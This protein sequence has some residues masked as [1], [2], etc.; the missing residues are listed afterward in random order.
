MAT[1]D[2]APETPKHVGLIPISIT[3]EMKK[4]FIEYSMSV[5]TSRALPDVRDGLKPVHRRILFAMKGM[6]LNAGGRFRK[7]AAVVGEVLGKYH[8]H[9]DSS[10]YDAMVNLAQDFSTRYPLVIGQGNFGSIDGDN[11]AAQRYTEAKMSR[12]SEE[13]LRDIEKN[14]VRFAPNYDGTHDEPTVLPASV[15][16]LLL[17]GVLGIAVGM[18]TNIPPHNLGEVI[19]ATT[20]LIDHSDAT[21]DD[22][23]EH[24]QGPDFPLGG[25][26]FNRQDIARAYA[27]GR[28]GVVTR[29]EAEIIETKTGKQEIIISSIPYRV[30]RSNLIIKIADLVRDKKL[31]GIKD[32]RDESTGV[33][34]IVVELKPGT[35][36]QRIL[37]YI[38]KHTDLE[39]SFN[40]NMTALVDGVPETLSLKGIL[41]NFIS[42]REDVVRLR[43][44]Y[45]LDKAEARAH[46]L[47]GLKKALDNIDKVIQTIKKSPDTA[48][49]KL[50][51]IKAFK[52]TEI[53]AQAILDMR[54]Q[55]L[56]GLERKAI[57]DE[58][59]E[60]LA[61]IK[62]LKELLASPKK[63]LATI[64][65][66][67]V[68]IRDKY[69]DERRTRVVAGGVR[70]IS[71]ED[72]VPNKDATLVFT[73][74]GYIKRT[75]PEEYRAQKRGGKGVNEM[76]T[77]EE[78]VITHL[79]V[80]NTHSNLLFF[81]D[82]G[83]VYSLKLY[84]I[85]EGKRT[86]RGKSINNF[87]ALTD[88]ERVTSILAVPK[89]V[90]AKDASLALVTKLGVIKKVDLES[91]GAV[92]RS[93][94]IAINLREQD[95]LLS[96]HI[97]QEED[98]VMV[99]THEGQAIRFTAADVRQMGRTAAGVRAIKLKKNDQ[100]VGAGVVKFEQ[101]D[102]MLLVVTEN[103]Y[104]KQTPV[105]E[106][107]IQ[108]R[109]GGGV[110]TVNLTTKT[111]K[112]VGA[113]VVVQENSEIIAI[114]QKSVI[115][116]TGLDEISELGRA[117]QG[118]RIMKLA[119]GDNVASIAL[120]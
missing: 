115:I 82:Q 105:T 73:A 30:N 75:D 27:T 88:G 43:T 119:T 66:E 25:I 52:F 110:K 13:L 64:R 86:S 33:T 96:A 40:Y 34:R 16:N 23:L 55:K 37:N 20:H 29:G 103:G 76:N 80:A 99:A 60:K 26:V 51:L 69:S 112:L 4:S 15:P 49:A 101:P 39:T 120:L 116:R 6:G 11:A 24:I 65:E 104:G 48:T 89:G 17:N 90:E 72:L 8:P 78:D 70:N 42:H 12:I 117:T 36:P 57:E 50:N 18:A 10:V 118:V 38:Y 85:P 100:V 5:I 107:K 92:R 108:G 94:L 91:F 114:S 31:Q 28:G 58:L 14:T 84:E 41:R 93:G 63:I 109:G 56:A 74:G 21:N 83:K 32:L 106:Y 98:Q 61:L 77:K 35:V 1:K 44:Q 3:E 7:S 97:V 79:M 2:S 67:L 68:A 113:K 62:S 53:Q 46:I 59:K 9:G 87:I 81:T 22:L 95:E 54:L 102:Q 71:D 45:D 47:E 111:G 19:D